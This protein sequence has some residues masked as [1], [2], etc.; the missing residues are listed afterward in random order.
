MKL[1]EFKDLLNNEDY[2]K[3]KNRK[4]PGTW[5]PLTSNVFILGEVTTG[6]VENGVR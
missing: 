3:C 5:Y 1:E 6:P 4:L 2:K